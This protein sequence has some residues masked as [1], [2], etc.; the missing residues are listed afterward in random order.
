MHFC[1][2]THVVRFG[3]GQGRVNYEVVQELL[4]R[5]HRVTLIATTI[6]EELSGRVE[7]V[8]LQPRLRKPALL[9][10]RAFS[11]LAEHALRRHLSHFDAVLANGATLRRSP[12]DVNVV[13]FVHHAWLHSPAHVSRVRRD[14]YGWYQW[15]YTR[16]NQRWERPA[17]LAARR[18]VAV[19]DRVRQDL[20]EA[21]LS[22]KNIVVINNGVDTTEFI[23]GPR[24][25]SLFGLPDRVPVGLFAGDIR[26]PRKNLESVLQ[27]LVLVPFLHIAVA[28]RLERSPYPAMAVRLGV[29]ERV[30]FLG[31]ERRMV[32]LMQAA[33]FLVFPSRFEPFGLVLLEAMA[34]GLPV[35]TARTA[36]GAR[37]I[38]PEDGFVIDDPE[39]VALLAGAMERL[40]SDVLL[41]ERMAAN[42]RATAEQYTF[43][44]MAA[45]Y[46]DLLENAARS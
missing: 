11:R 6:A 38:G 23:P 33:D 37:L 31:F 19:S 26:T 21:G 9:N 32:Q 46:A 41:R 34:A 29:A 15:L 25:R 22:E 4:R 28:G 3:D 17:L 13:H 2:I 44:R 12:H 42:A 35:I 36:G 7:W 30:H 24:D 16:L 40:A 8:R 27:A 18:V 39:N 5:G 45:S 43:G 14:P 1:V 20:M 10:N